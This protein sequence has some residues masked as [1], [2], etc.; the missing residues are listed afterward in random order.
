MGEGFVTA[1][2][3]PRIN[4]NLPDRDKLI[5]IVNPNAL[6]NKE[7][8]VSRRH[9]EGV[10]KKKGWFETDKPIEDFVTSRPLSGPE[11]VMQNRIK[12]LEEE[13][14]RLKREGKEETSNVNPPP[15]NDPPPDETT[16]GPIDVNRPQSEVF[17]D[18]RK[19]TRISILKEAMEAEF[20]PEGQKRSG[21]KSVIEKRI[22]ELEKTTN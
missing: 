8:F 11:Q 22:G 5:R 2:D 3:L 21:L 19:T 14:Q 20:A 15:A 6:K 1:E 18:V 9:Y 7:Q 16:E 17:L 13:N 12:A 10:L 4:K